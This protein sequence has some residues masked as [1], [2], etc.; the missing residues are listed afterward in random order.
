MSERAKTLA[1]L[2][3][4]LGVM[5]LMAWVG[6]WPEFEAQRLSRQTAYVMAGEASNVNRD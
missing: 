5:F 6:P 1:A 3:A 2:A 4:M